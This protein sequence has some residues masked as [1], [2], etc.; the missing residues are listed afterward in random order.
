M[1]QTT[2]STTIEESRAREAAQADVPEPKQ[3]DDLHTEHGDT[4]IAD[5]VVQKIAGVAAREVAGVYAMG[6]A[7]G[8]AISNLSQRIPGS[9][10]NVSGGVSVAKGERQTAVDVSIVVEYGVSIPDV[11]QQIR[12]SVISA[13]EYATGLEVVE[14]NINV[15]DV[16]LPEDDTEQSTTDAPQLA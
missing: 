10:P 8:R 9:K 4:S 15:S 3:L 12:E 7:A 14:V 13:V 16:H 1:S 11:S 6:S 2:L 5:Q